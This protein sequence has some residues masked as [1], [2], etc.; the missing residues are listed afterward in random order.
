[1][2][3]SSLEL[4]AY[5][6]LL[7]VRPAYFVSF[8]KKTLGIKRRAIELEGGRHFWIDPVS[9]FGLELLREGTYEPTM[10]QLIGTLLRPGD[11][12]VDI[13]GNEGYFSMVASQIVGRGQVHCVEPQRRLQSV[14]REN[15][16]LNRAKNIHVHALALADAEATKELH[17]RP[18]TNTGSSGFYGGRKWGS[19]TESVSVTTLDKFFAIHGIER[20]RLMKVDCE[21]AE[22]PMMVGAE[23]VFSSRRIDFLALEFH[24]NVIGHAKCTEIN[25]QLRRSGYRLTRANAL[26]VYHLPGL[27]KDLASLGTLNEIHWDEKGEITVGAVLLPNSTRAA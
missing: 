19:K 20:A 15:I 9:Q 18:D 2:N 17:L 24:P 12:F 5:S 26:W 11:T 10:T 27:E 8:L 16:S 3:G 25:S 14:I 7:R 1:M 23:E 4:C 6:K 22:A 13:G 21:G